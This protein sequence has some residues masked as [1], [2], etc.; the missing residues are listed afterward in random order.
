[1]RKLVIALIGLG[2]VFILGM[3]V[4]VLYYY[5]NYVNPKLTYQK[6]EELFNNGD[7]VA[8]A[9]RFSSMGG[10]SNAAE[11]A[12]R[13]WIAAGDEAFELGEL[14]QAAAYYKKGLAGTEYTSKVDVAYYESGVAHY[15]NGDR[16]HAEADFSCISRN[17]ELLSQLDA[18]R[19]EYARVHINKDD[20]S[21]AEKALTMCGDSSGDTIAA[22]WLD[23]GIAKLHLWE[24]SNASNCFSKALMYTSDIDSML[25][26]VERNWKQAGQLAEAAKNYD[27]AEKCYAHSGLVYDADASRKHNAYE[28]AVEVYNTGDYIEALR[29]FIALG[30]YSDCE[31]R[32]T[33]IQERLKTKLVAG[34][35][36]FYATLEWDG[37]VQIHGDWEDYSAP[38]WADIE[39]LSVGRYRFMVGIRSDGTVVANGNN[40]WGNLN[41]TDWSN[42]VQVACGYRHTL[43]LK[44]D[45]TVL[46]VGRDTYGQRSHAELWTNIVQIACGEDFSIGL[47][48][49]GTVVSAGLKSNGQ[50]NTGF[51]DDIV[52]VGCGAAHTVALKSDGTVYA[53]GS[54][55]NGQCNVGTWSDFVEIFVGTN[56]TVGLTRNGTLVATG[57]NSLGE[58]NVRDYTDVL[59]V[60][61]GANFTLIMLKD[62]TE[63]KLGA[64][65]NVN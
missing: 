51:M 40:T 53:T 14:A 26:E 3:A 47:K 9:I 16:T 4:F 19:I 25:I 7:Y 10:Y 5:P 44:S 18:I 37:S 65:N 63:I 39:V 22:M 54:N 52:Q 64:I 2:A 41:V 50:C 46:A 42:I 32:A 49:D 6:T 8:A 27:L 60:S 59:Y 43:G 13:A 56:H 12:S 36:I 48:D 45:G 29:Q 1:M 34:G 58:C 17:S 23:R 57:S 31:Q 38:D 61:C 33:Q 15:L 11:Y 35:Y 55:N 24:L 28:T 62:G 20:Y 21:S 30:N